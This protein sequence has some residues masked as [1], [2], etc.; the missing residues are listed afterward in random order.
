[1]DDA[2][3]AI[4]TVRV[5]L[6]EADRSCPAAPMAVAEVVIVNPAD[7]PTG[8]LSVE[9]MTL[10]GAWHRWSPSVTVDGRRI[11]EDE[12]ALQAIW[13]GKDESLMDREARFFVEGGGRVGS[14]APGMQRTVAATFT[15]T[16]FPSSGGLDRGGVARIRD[17]MG[18]VVAESRFWFPAASWFS[19]TARAETRRLRGLALGPRR[20]GIDVTAEPTEA[21]GVLVVRA[22]VLTP[23]HLPDAKIAFNLDGGWSYLAEDGWSFVPASV[24]LD[25]RLVLPEGADSVGADVFD[26]GDDARVSDFGDFGGKVGPLRAGAPLVVEAQIVAQGMVAGTLSVSVIG[27]DVEET[28]LARGSCPLPPTYGPLRHRMISSGDSPA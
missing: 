6:R 18:G 28:L 20:V 27:R 4:P 15:H 3:A 7:I 12:E 23:V 9:L 2:S 19:E 26:P 25:G 10:D 17:D 8:P 14:L 11:V 24:R 13:A 16:W 1:M 21:P 5:V 22:V